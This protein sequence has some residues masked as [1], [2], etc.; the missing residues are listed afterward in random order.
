MT[1]EVEHL[2]IAA[3][4][5]AGVRLDDDQT[6]AEVEADHNS[7]RPCETG[8]IMFINFAD[9]QYCVAATP[10][11]ASYRISE[12]ASRMRTT[13]QNLKASKSEYIDTEP[14][15]EDPIF[16]TEES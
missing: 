6:A 12:L 5:P 14:D 3:A 1:S 11:L 2:L 7:R 15:D 16:W 10:G 4:L 8:D 13:G 9:D